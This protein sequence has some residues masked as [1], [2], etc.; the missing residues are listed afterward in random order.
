MKPNLSVYFFILVLAF[1]GSVKAQ[2]IDSLTNLL[3]SQSASEQVKTLKEEWES[4]QQNNFTYALSV[5]QLGLST[6]KQQQV[7]STIVFFQ[8]AM[9]KSFQ[10]LT[11]QDSAMVYHTKS[12]E[13]Y[14]KANN[15]KQQ[16][17]TLNEMARIQRKL[18]N[19]ERALAFYDEAMQLYHSIEDK[20]GEAIIFNES[21]V[22][23]AQM[24]N[25]E[26]ADKNYRSSLAIQEQRKDS[27]GIGYSLEFIGYNY[28]LQEQFSSAERYLQ[29]ALQIR[30]AINDRFALC[31]NNHV[32][33]D[34]YSKMGQYNRSASYIKRSNEL[35]K[36]L[37]YPDI[38]RY[39]YEVLIRN[40]EEQGNFQL[41]L[42]NQRKL[43]ELNDS[44][45]AIEKVKNVEEL[46]VKYETA[47]KE[48][49]LFA[50]RAT[51]AEQQLKLNK[52]FMWISVLLLSAIAIGLIGYLFY[53]K[54]RKENSYKM[55]LQ[56]IQAKENLEA[57]RLSISR[58]LHDNIGAQ[59]TFI[60]S[61]LQMLRHGTTDKTNPIHHKISEIQSFT[62]QTIQ[63][64]RDTVWAMNQTDI[65]IA[66]LSTRLQQFL[67]T[68]NS[69]SEQ[70]QFEFTQ[71]IKSTDYAFSS[72]EGI[73][74]FRI[75]QEAIHNAIKHANATEIQLN[76][77]EQ[78]N[79]LLFTVADNGIGFPIENTTAS[80]GLKN[81]QLRAN[82]MNGEYEL[83]SSDNGTTV[84]LR[85]PL[86]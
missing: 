60:I 3:E 11:Q 35:S 59:L 56:T 13:G 27:V 37:A 78:S 53:Q 41:A 31:L 28:L 64:L 69:S 73:H 10:K 32:L 14:R 36:E 17:E 25:H 86:N 12:L 7:D 51:V 62:K 4:A 29:Q 21:G 54:Q 42:S 8:S 72:E 5:A 71:D 39:N 81:M 57:Q 20:E 68:A 23:Y 46:T 58:D 24:G 83:L 19:N 79:K 52:Q 16:A 80:N 75:V 49:E 15:V 44:L 74:L 85:V 26:Q 66:Q 48:R 33:G 38:R 40:S 50:E 77:K 55:A 22:V 45:Y 6:A 18:Q 43:N 63:E 67:T 47:E 82:Q 84:N 34:L 30:E 70:I 65:T 61:A 76:V 2:S 9:G 1:V